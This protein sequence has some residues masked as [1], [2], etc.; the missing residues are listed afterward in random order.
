VRFVHAIAGLDDEIDVFVRGND[1]PIVDG[2]GYSTEAGWNEED[3]MQG[4]LLVRRE[5]SETALAT[6]P[7]VNLEAGKSYTF[8]LTGTPTKAEVIQFTDNVAMDPDRDDAVPDDR[9]DKRQ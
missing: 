1:N 5:N 7:N 8:I 4:T 2:V 6:I 9:A 3:P